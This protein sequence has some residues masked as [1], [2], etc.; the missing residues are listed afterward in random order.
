MKQ[1]HFHLDFSVTYTIVLCKPLV[2]HDLEKSNSVPDTNNASHLDP[3][4][5]RSWL[6]TMRLGSPSGAGS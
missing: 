1:T 3:V 5:W 4:R 6:T 2:P